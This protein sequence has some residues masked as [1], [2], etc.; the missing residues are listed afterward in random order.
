MAKSYTLGDVVEMLRARQG[1]GT[2]TALAEE[3]G[4]TKAYISDIYKGRRNPGPT[5]LSFLGIVAEVT[6][7]TRYTRAS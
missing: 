2:L 3:I 5:I 1:N 4:V 7:E 6:T